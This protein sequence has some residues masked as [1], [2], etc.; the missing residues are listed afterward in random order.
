M[1]T[2]NELHTEAFPV[3]DDDEAALVADLAVGLA[4]PTARVLAYL[5]AR[6]DS[7][8]VDAE[9]ASKLDVRVGAGL[10]RSKI[11]A[12][13]SALEGRDVVER[14]TAEGQS[15]GRPT[16]EWAATG[17]AAETTARIRET[18]AA[19][20]LDRATRTADAF[21]VR[22]SRASTDLDSNVR[23]GLNWAPNCFHAPL[24]AAAA[25]PFADRGFDVSFTTCRGSRSALERLQSGDADVVVGGGAT[26]VQ[27]QA[28]GSPVVPLALLSQRAAT[29]LY[30]TRD[31]FGAVFES[32]EQARGCRVAMP[33]GSETAALSR[34]LLSQAGVIEDVTVVESTGEERH[35]LLEG[36]ADVVTGMATDVHD[37]RRE[38]YAVDSVLLSDHFPA[39]GPALV[40]R[41][42]TLRGDADRLSA[43]LEATMVGRRAVER[44]PATAA[45]SLAEHSQ[46]TVGDERRRLE[47]V[48]ERFV[49]SEATRKHG[50]GWHSVDGWRRLRT[51]LEQ[52]NEPGDRS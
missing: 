1:R 13:L 26:V 43:F 21:E 14:T 10:G 5:V 41:E 40:V 36:D 49:D 23:V 32:V 37:L 30:T 31:A 20:L 15:R 50:W 12:A 8:G 35:E 45:A 22:D 27:A 3:L 6:R 39:Y 34:L 11:E 42:S 29:T 25:G 47:T 33:T 51:A 16:A 4:D 18:H 9:F 46:R 48:L 7:D 19:A 38:G 17:N 28:E 52:A 24:V 44:D 2:A